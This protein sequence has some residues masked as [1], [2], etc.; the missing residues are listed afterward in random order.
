MISLFQVYFYLILAGTVIKGHF[1]MVKCVCG[2]LT[3]LFKLLLAV[4]LPEF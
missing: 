3:G 1:R 2:N 4:L